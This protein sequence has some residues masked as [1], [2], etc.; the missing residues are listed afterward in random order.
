M[1]EM[2][3]TES[4]VEIALV[5]ARKADAKRITAIHLKIGAL[6]GI[7]ADS[8]SFYMDLV[9]KG[10]LAEGARLVTTVLPVTAHCPDCGHDFAVEDMVFLCPKCGGPG[11]ILTGRELLIE[12]LEIE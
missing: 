9:A 7:V 2:A 10:T 12:S 4:L 6:T 5:E 8:V 3:I 1:H 11:Q